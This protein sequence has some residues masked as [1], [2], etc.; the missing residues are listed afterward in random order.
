[1]ATMITRNSQDLILPS[2]TDVAGE[3]ERSN[4]IKQ[5]AQEATNE[6]TEERP[7][8]LGRWDE[9][10]AAWGQGRFNTPETFDEARKA[11]FSKDAVIDVGRNE[12]AGVKAFKEYSFDT[13]N[14]WFD[15]LGTFDLSDV[16]VNAVLSSK[17]ASQLWQQLR[18]TATSKATG[19]S[20]HIELLSIIDFDGAMVKRIT[21]LYA[22]PKRHAYLN[23][24]EETLTQVQLPSFEP[25]PDPMPVYEALFAMWAAGDFANAETKA[26][27]FDKTAHPQAVLDAS[28]AA[29]PAD[30]FKTYHGHA[31]LDEW[32]NGVVGKWEFTRMD[33]TAAVGL[34]PGCVMQRL[35]CD[36]KY[37]GKE[38]NGIVIY[39]ELAYNTDGKAVY[40]K[41][42]WANPRVVA[43]LYGAEC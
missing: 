25:H 18:C 37:E 12:H 4:S 43:S 36:V 26:A 39:V 23:G 8:A 28:N 11:F 31:G 35:D 10:I 15:Y 6:G 14:E 21:N 22:D 5:A 24:T 41:L 3:A 34:K 16:A 1:M 19:K 42:F 29:L 9:M 17:D 33:V 2:F 27:N 38:A 40:N 32:A 30:I 7:I 20:A 13:M